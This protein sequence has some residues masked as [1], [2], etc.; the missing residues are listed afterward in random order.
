MQ[1]SISGPLNVPIRLAQLWNHLRRTCA[2]SSQGT[3]RAWWKSI[4]STIGSCLRSAI[5]AIM[6]GK[7]RSGRWRIRQSRCK[8]HRRSPQAPVSMK[9]E[10]QEDHDRNNRDLAGEFNS[11]IAHVLITGGESPA[12]SSRIT[13]LQVQEEY[14]TVHVYDFPSPACS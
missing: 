3:H 6:R 7:V 12:S 8:G 5:G 10:D 9:V 13:V 11:V 14:N 1:C 4:T 2:D